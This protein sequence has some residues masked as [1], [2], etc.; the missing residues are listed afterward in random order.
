M[1][2]EP[3]EVVDA[4]GLLDADWAEI[5][6]LRKVLRH[7]GQKGWAIAFDELIDRDFFQ[8]AR[9]MMAVFPSLVPG[10]VRDELASR[11]ITQQDLLD[12]IRELESPAR[13]Q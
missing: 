6:R 1:T 5:N 8:S 7:S 3:W 9:I 12:A 11:G 4:S 13:D 2:G 10:I